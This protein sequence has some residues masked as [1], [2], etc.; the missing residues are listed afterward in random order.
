MVAQKGEQ[1]TSK[2]KKKK[3]K[4]DKL[5]CEVCGLTVTVDEYCGCVDVCDLICCGQEME[6]KE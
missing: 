2:K 6:L 3:E 4:G 1:K 5:V